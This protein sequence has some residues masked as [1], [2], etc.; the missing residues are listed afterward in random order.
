MR[1]SDSRIAVGLPKDQ[2]RG[3]HMK[4]LIAWDDAKESNLLDPYL[5]TDENQIAITHSL[6]E[7]PTPTSK[8]RWD[9][10]LMSLTFPTADDGLKLFTQ[11]Q[12]DLPGVPILLACR[13]TEM[14]NLPRFLNR[15]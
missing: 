2:A 15:G 8:D 9:A 5:N 12:Q 13:P 3:M 14:I 6:A 10:V 1:L 11:L 4:I 7:M